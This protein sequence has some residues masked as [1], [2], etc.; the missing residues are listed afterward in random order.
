MEH[1]NY[2][3]LEFIDVLIS[4]YITHVDRKLPEAFTIGDYNFE[5]PIKKF[6]FV[7]L[8]VDNFL[9]ELFTANAHA[10]TEMVHSFFLNWL[11]LKYGKA[12]K[13]IIANTNVY[14]QYL[15]HYKI[16]LEPYKNKI[17]YYALHE[18]FLK[19][20]LPI[21]SK[22][23]KEIVVLCEN[24]ISD[25]LGYSDNISLIEFS[26]L[27]LSQNKGDFSQHNFPWV[28][29]MF[30]TLHLFIELL[31]PLAI[32][33]IEGNHPQFESL[34]L[35]GKQKSIPVICLQQG[36]PSILHTGFKDMQYSHFLCWGP[37]FG[38]L[39]KP[40]NPL[41]HFM[42]TGY[43]F[44][45]AAKNGKVSIAFF[46]QAPI[47]LSSP[48]VH[49]SILEFAL[50]CAGQFPDRKIL[51]R[52]HPEYPLSNHFVQQAANYDNIQLTPQNTHTLFE[53]FEKSLISVSIFSST[54][55]ESLAHGT[56]P[57]IFNPGLM[58]NY[59]P[60]LQAEGLGVEV[61][62]L[63]DA[64]SQMIKL[65]G[66][67]SWSDELLNQINAKRKNYFNMTHTDATKKTTNTIR[68]IC[69]EL[70]NTSCFNQ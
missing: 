43:P 52:E 35:I 23:G 26:H 31:Q 3:Y 19:F 59:N 29:H 53:V 42:V 49:N 18:R 6:L 17:V 39:F 10:N 38:E 12:P 47:L 16:L 57:F 55:I 41:P 5:V 37:R 54:I 14:N 24:K 67:P 11:L 1:L 44:K 4:E 61:K 32:L 51:I 30:N 65:I 66:S 21:L 48:D 36:W 9:K 64:K 27:P 63:E 40:M 20:M 62:S 46:L 50:F 28:F 34:A 58:P 68:A 56:I 13:E 2:K 60:N 22:L 70:T 33:V 7:R 45:T 25:D 8:A 69:H 15:N